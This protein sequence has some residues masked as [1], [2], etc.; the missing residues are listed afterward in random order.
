MGTSASIAALWAHTSSV[1]WRRHGTATATCRGSSEFASIGSRSSI[2]S[3]TTSNGPDRSARRCPELST[4]G[5]AGG[6][7][8][9]PRPSA[10][11]RRGLPGPGLGHGGGGRPLGGDQ[12][13]VVLLLPAGPGGALELAP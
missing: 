6:I 2:G 10:D 12:G 13:G 9:A 11:G 3:S 8:E 1:P 7:Q 5:V 4:Q